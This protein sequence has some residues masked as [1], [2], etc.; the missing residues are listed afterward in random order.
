MIGCAG[1][2]RSKAKKNQAV[3]KLFFF[4]GVAFLI[5]LLIFPTDATQKNFLLVIEFPEF[6]DMDLE[7]IKPIILAAPDS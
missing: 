5:Y 6:S 2:V 1:G 7:A 4:S 3:L